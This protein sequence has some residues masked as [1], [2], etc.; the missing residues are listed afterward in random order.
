MTVYF[1]EVIA[2][3]PADKREQVV[4]SLQLVAQAL[5]GPRCC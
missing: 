1:E 2:A 5:K 4:E 3:I